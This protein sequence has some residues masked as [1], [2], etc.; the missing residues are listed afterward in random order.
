MTHAPTLET[1]RLRL[2]R[3]SLDDYPAFE[4]YFADPE[5]SAPNG[6]PLTPDGA[7]MRFCAEIGHWSAAGYGV[8]AVA[9]REDDAFIGGV[10][11]RRIESWGVTKMVW[12]ILPSFRRMGF[13]A[14]ASR[15]A[16]AHAC[17]AW[18]WTEMETFAPDHNMAARALIARLGGAPAGRRIFADGSERDAFR[19]PAPD[20]AAES[21]ERRSAP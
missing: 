5:A 14:E 6:G 16:I 13:A 12:F 18:R 19:L 20:D 7:W 9:R 4:I 1:E 21:T 17:D 8:W 10:G 15:A 2:R 11:F 3:F